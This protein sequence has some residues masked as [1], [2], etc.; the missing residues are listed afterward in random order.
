MDA[1]PA[2]GCDARGNGEARESSCPRGDLRGIA[3]DFSR[4][5]GTAALCMVYKS[6]RLLDFRVRVD[7]R[8]VR[9]N[10]WDWQLLVYAN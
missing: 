8:G 9:E 7:R 2:G 1:R 4:A 3:G 10:G 5:A 6:V